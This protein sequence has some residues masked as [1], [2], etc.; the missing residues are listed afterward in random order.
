[1]AMK[2]LSA[3]ADLFNT[4]YKHDTPVHIA[5]RAGYSGSEKIVITDIK[6]LKSTIDS[7]KEKNLFLVFVG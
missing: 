5:Y 7:E 1:M 6:G 4:I 2:D 3:M